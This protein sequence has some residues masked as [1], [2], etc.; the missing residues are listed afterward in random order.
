MDLQLRK[1]AA[2]HAK[3]YRSYKAYLLSLIHI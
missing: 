3:C 2:R 1:T